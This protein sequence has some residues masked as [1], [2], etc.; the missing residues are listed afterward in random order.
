MFFDPKTGNITGIIPE[1]LE[2]LEIS[3]KSTNLDGTT[4]VLN[5]KLDLKE[6]KKSQA[7]QAEVEEKYIGLKE[8]IALENQKLDGYGSYLTRLFA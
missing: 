3:I 4:K 2:K 8:Q 1:D 7:N 5:L 6:L